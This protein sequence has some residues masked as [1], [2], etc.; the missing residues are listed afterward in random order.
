[1][2]NQGKNTNNRKKHNLEILSINGAMWDFRNM[3]RAEW[4]KNN[5]Y[6]SRIQKGEN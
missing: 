2:Q 6:I 1:M 5:K 3:F 4:G